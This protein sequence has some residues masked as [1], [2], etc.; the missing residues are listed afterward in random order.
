MKAVKFSRADGPMA[1]LFDEKFSV[2]MKSLKLRN[3]FQKKIQSN[4]LFAIIFGLTLITR[5][6][7][8]Y[9]NQKWTFE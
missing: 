3:T 7:L 6:F 4:F 1:I 8:N 9:Q 5:V 2:Y